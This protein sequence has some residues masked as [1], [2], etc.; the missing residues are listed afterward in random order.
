MLYITTWPKTKIEQK[1]R[2]DGVRRDAGEM[3]RG[4]MQR[5][6]MDNIE[7]LKRT[8]ILWREMDS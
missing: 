6:T 2:R 7:E 3:E 5:E 1:N 8:S 4:H